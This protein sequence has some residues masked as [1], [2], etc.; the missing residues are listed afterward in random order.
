MREHPLLLSEPDAAQNANRQQG[1]AEQQQAHLLA[2]WRAL[3]HKREQRRPTCARCACGTH[4]ECCTADGLSWPRAERG[5]C[6]TE[7]KPE[8]TRPAHAT[9]DDVQ[10]EREAVC[11]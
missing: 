10:R 11:V 5:P 7:P 9:F 2:R 1:C 8:P 4:V 3:E 6:A